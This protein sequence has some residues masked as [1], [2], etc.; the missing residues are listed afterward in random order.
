MASLL[1][2]L[3]GVALFGQNT[4][5]NFVVTALIVALAAQGWNLLGGYC[6]QFSF[7]HAAFF[8]TG[9]YVTAA[10]QSRY[11][12]NAWAGAGIGIAAG[13]AIGWVIGWL[14]FRAG[15]RGSY[16]AL[17]TLAFAEVLRIVANATPITGGGTGLLLKLDVRASNFQFSSRGVFCLVALACVMLVLAL[18]IWLARSRLGAQFAA[19][20]ENEDAARALGIDVLATKLRAIALSGAVTA[21]AGC[22]YAQYFL[23]LD[24]NIA[25]G[26][27]ISVESLLAVIVGGIATPAGPIIGALAL[28][29]LGEGTRLLAGRITGIDLVLFGLILVAATAFAPS[30]IAGAWKALS[31]RVQ[32]ARA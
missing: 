26:S 11:G 8:G 14:S 17:I 29:A 3:V 23:Y 30:G 27:W 9:A 25:Y 2:A 19:V 32:R 16:F 5:I 6:G 20:R 22:L 10:L 4:S 24:S 18:T 31:A 1:L 7:G 28:H 15:L 12:V 21:A 13:A